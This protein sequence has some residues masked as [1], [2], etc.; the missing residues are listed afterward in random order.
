MERQ[1]LFAALWNCL[2]Q[3]NTVTL[4]ELEPGVQCFARNYDV[5]EDWY[6][7]PGSGLTEHDF[8]AAGFRAQR[9]IDVCCEG[10]SIF[11]TRECLHL[12]CIA[13]GRKNQ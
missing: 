7:H 4:S 5:P 13:V 2:G 1:E 6:R 12:M 8:H 3:W 10:R 9:V 11:V